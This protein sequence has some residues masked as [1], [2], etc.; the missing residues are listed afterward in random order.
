MPDMFQLGSA[1]TIH[2]DGSSLRDAQ[3][4]FVL[5]RGFNFGARSKSA[6]FLPIMPLGVK[7]LDA[8]QFQSELSAVT[9]QL[10]LM[11]QIGVSA[12]RLLVMWKALEPV[13]G[14]PEQLQPQ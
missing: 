6:P 5:L 13:P 3:G 8:I 7:T 2:K 1:R 9:P 14:N 12:V 4:R 11:Q 10:D